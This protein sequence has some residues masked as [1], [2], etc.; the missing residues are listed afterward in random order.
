MAQGLKVDVGQLDSLKNPLPLAQGTRT[1]PSMARGTVS[2]WALTL[3][4]KTFAPPSTFR[5]SA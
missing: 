2:I 5:F 4:N 3:C 1:Y